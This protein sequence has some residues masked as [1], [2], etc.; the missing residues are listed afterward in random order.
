MRS[1]DQHN[2]TGSEKTRKIA[3][4]TWGAAEPVPVLFPGR[5]LDHVTGPDLL[6]RSS[7]ALDEP[8]ARGHDQSLAQRMNVPRRPRARLEGDARPEAA[9]RCG[10]LEERVDAYPAREVLGPS[11]CG[12][13]GAASLDLDAGP[14]ST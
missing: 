1:V 3:D 9:R 4:G 7:L 11:L 6:S 8:A 10:R 13:L 14:F 5:A 2:R 12:R